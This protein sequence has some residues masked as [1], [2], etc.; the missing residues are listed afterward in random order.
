MTCLTIP[1]I[2][3]AMTVAGWLSPAMDGHFYKPLPT[4]N[5]YQTKVYLQVK[6]DLDSH[7]CYSGMT[8]LLPPPDA[9]T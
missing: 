5:P 2:V 9:R 3:A 8:H 6:I 7:G 1:M 4:D